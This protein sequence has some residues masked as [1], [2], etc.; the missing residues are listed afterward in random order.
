MKLSFANVFCNR[1]GDRNGPVKNGDSM[2]LVK[3]LS[4]EIVPLVSPSPPGR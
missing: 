3:I 2:V 1:P 4:L